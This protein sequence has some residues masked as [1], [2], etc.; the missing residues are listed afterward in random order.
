MSY[1]ISLFALSKCIE[2]PGFTPNTF[3]NIFDRINTQFTRYFD[4]L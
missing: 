1:H 2:W 4:K 3:L